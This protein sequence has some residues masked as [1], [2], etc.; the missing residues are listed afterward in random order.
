MTKNKNLYHLVLTAILSALIVVMTV[1][2][3]TGYISYGGVIEITTLHI[4]TIVGAVFLGWKGGAVLGGV[5]GL[6]CIFR[7]MTNPLWAAFMNPL[8]SL[9]PRVL[10]GV[11]AALVFAGLCKIR[12][13]RYLSSI[14][15]AIAA[16]LTNTLLVLSALALF[17]DSINGFFELMKTVYLTVI[18]INGLIELAA[19][20]ILTPVLTFAL[21][22][23]HRD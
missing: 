21:S 11:V 10:V 12:V 7:A 8:V 14:I 20:A 18:G 2:P 19:A 22:K 1:V 3:Y 4:V 23:V 9:V 6:T 13:N 15:A 5:W 17:G 16:T